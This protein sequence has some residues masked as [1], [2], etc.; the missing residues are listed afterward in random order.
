MPTSTSKLRDYYLMGRTTAGELDVED[1]Y[2]EDELERL[3]TRVT[4]GTPLASI[5]SVEA[6]KFI[7]ASE[8]LDTFW[9]KSNRQ[10]IKADKVDPKAAYEAFRRGLEETAVLMVCLVIDAA[11]DDLSEDEEDE[12]D[13]GEEENDGEGDD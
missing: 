2:D 7:N 1:A 4:D 3:A 13:D 12:E 11:M 9:L 10:E 6:Q 5:A 8:F